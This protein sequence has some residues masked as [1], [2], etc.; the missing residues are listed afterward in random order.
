MVNHYM[1][2]VWCEKT[3]KNIPGYYYTKVP[4]L[5]RTIGYMHQYDIDGLPTESD[6]KEII[7]RSKL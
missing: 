6:V 4:I 2:K 1:I 7:Y 3:K 5:P